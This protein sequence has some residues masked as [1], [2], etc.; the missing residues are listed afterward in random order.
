MFEVQFACWKLGAVFVPWNWRL[1]APELEYMVQEC[2]PRVLLH[3]TEFGA[4]ATAL[5]LVPE[6]V[7]WDVGDDGRDAYEQLLAAVPPGDFPRAEPTLETLLMIMSTS[8]TT[9]RPKGVLITHGMALW[10]VLN[11]TEFF[12]TSTDMVN[13]AILPLFTTGGLNC[14]ANPAFHYGGTNVVMGPFDAAVA[15]HLLDDPELKITHTQAVPSIWLFMSSDRNSPTRRS[16]R[17]SA[18]V[19][20]D[21]PRRSRCSGAGSTRGSPSSRRSG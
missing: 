4:A 11:Q 8:G 6:R 21:R 17:W 20:A 19:W 9:G 10:N 13:L 1:A 3:G 2:S 16:R 12:R 18:R 5:A 14:F 7:A 15:L